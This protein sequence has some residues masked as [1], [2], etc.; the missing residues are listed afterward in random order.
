MLALGSSGPFC[1]PVEAFLFLPDYRYFGITDEIY[2][3][4]LIR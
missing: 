3:H 1:L 4:Q 2:S